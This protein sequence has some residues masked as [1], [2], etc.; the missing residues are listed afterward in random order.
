MYACMQNGWLHVCVC[1]IICEHEKDGC[2]LVYV[3]ILAHAWYVYIY[4]HM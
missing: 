1:F 3:L 4:I 2:M